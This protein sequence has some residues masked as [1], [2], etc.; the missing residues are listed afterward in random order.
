MLKRRD[1][2]AARAWIRRKDRSPSLRTL[3]RTGRSSGRPALEQYQWSILVYDGLTKMKH[4]VTLRDCQ[5][6]ILEPSLD[7]MVRYSRGMGTDTLDRRGRETCGKL[8]RSSVPKTGNKEFDS[9][10]PR[11]YKPAPR[12][13]DCS[14]FARAFARRVDI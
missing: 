5:R 10:S 12:R 7:V 1:G 11:A 13:A 4:A 6:Q 14:C 9:A 8:R 3:N 2:V